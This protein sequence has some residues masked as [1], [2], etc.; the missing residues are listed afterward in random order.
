M[1]QRL[2]L[3]Q[4]LLNDPDLLV[5]DE[6]AEG[7][8]LVGRALLREVIAG[9]KAKG[10]TVV[11]VSHVLSEVEQTCDRVAVIV[12]GKVV[13]DAAL[14]DLTRDPKSGK[15]RSLEQALRPLYEGART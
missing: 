12:N 11:L 7:L 8:D 10:K 5:L 9:R 14:A 6:P 3:A 15:P 13:K 2:G 4:A 1:V